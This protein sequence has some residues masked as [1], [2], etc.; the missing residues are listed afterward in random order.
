M[1]KDGKRVDKKDIL[2]AI[3]S[4][5]VRPIRNHVDSSIAIKN[6][7]LERL[8]NIGYPSGSMG[9]LQYQS[10]IDGMRKILALI[11]KDPHK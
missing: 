6:D 1:I 7:S 10:Q 8:K 5:N 2:P 3:K 11:D 9:Y 4:V